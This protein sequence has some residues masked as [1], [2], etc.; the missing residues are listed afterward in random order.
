MIILVPG[1]NIKHAIA[2]NTQK[3]TW[4]S[5]NILGLLHDSPG[6]TKYEYNML[7]MYDI[8]HIRCV[9]NTFLYLLFHRMLCW[10]P[11]LHGASVLAK[12][13]DVVNINYQIHEYCEKRTSE[14][15]LECQLCIYLLIWLNIQNLYDQ[16]REM[17]IMHLLIAHPV[18]WRSF[19]SMSTF[20]SFCFIL[21]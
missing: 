21:D 5:G 16:G 6:S 13:R 7:C 18:C 14:C 20:V 9:H 8:I 10:S 15:F 4:Q 17:N 3:K 12:S 1:E 19:R 11:F 2:S